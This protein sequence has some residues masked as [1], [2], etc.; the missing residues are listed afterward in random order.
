MAI[1]T[2]LKRPPLGGRMH[3]GWIV[4]AVTI[5]SVMI[6]AG[7]RSTPGVLIYPI[8]QEFGWT[9][10]AISVSVSIGLLLLGLSG[11]LTGQFIERFGAR[12]L[13]LFGLSLAGISLAG[14]TLVNTVWQ[15]DLVWG[16]ANG[17]ATGA[18][19]SVLGV[20]VANRWF[21]ARR[22]MVLG[23][24]SAATSAGQLIFLPALMSLVI[25][26]G[27]RAAA[28]GL[29]AV[30]M[31]G[32]L[33]ILVLMRDD[34][35]DVGLTPYGTT[36]PAPVVKQT[37][38]LFGDAIGRALRTRPFWSLSGAFFVCGATSSGL[39]GTHLVAHSIEHGIPEMEAAGALAVMGAVNLVGALTSGWLS[40]R[41]DPRKLLAFWFAI[42]AVSLFWLPFVT[43]FSGLAIFAVIFGF[44]YAATM[45]PTAALAADIFGRRNV[46]TIYGW[47]F[48]AH[49]IGSALAAYLGGVAR[50]NLGNYQLAF[51]IAGGI[52]LTGSAVALTVDRTKRQGLATTA[53]NR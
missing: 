6:G 53:T 4:V 43:D 30:A 51:V 31:A 36:S 20:S 24:F 8:E 12:R 3:Y 18:V 17:L 37:S 34:P 29:A 9:R 10:D 23:L 16:L 44:D 42:R 1:A 50:T 40:D 7:V 49:Q 38:S 11:P 48:F 14:S 26:N 41:V 47:I 32:L 21:V 19:A 5:V 35:A 22:G 33:P 2:N 28:L 15:L 13:M 45:P 25:S 46:A 39:I 52:A 27:W